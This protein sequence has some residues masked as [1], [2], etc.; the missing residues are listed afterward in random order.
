MRPTSAMKK[1]CG[2]PS[3]ARH[4]RAVQSSLVL[5]R[6][7]E[8]GDQASAVRGALWASRE[9]RQQRPTR[10]HTTCGD[11]TQGYKRRDGDYGGCKT[12]GG[13]RSRRDAKRRRGNVVAATSGGV[14]K[15]RPERLP[16]TDDAW[17]MPADISALTGALPSTP[18]RYALTDPRCL[19]C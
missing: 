17:A 16:A 5:S 14:G 11:G 19:L 6:K 4:R 2:R 9:G 1:A 13:E 3:S 12:T 18:H 7:R 10:S 8:S 15:D